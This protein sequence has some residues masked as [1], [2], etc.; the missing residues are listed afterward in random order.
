MLSNSESTSSKT[1]SIVSNGGILGR[2]K[3]LKETPEGLLQEKTF[4]HNILALI[5]ISNKLIKHKLFEMA[6]EKDNSPIDSNDFGG[7]VMAERDGFL[8]VYCA[9]GSEIMQVYREKA[10][11]KLISIAKG[12]TGHMFF[13][14]GEQAQGLGQASIKLWMVHANLRLS[15]LVELKMV[16][17]N[18]QE[19]FFIREEFAAS[20]SK[21]SFCVWTKID[22]QQ[23]TASH[24]HHAHNKA[25]DDITTTASFKNDQG[26]TSNARSVAAN[27]SGLVCNNTFCSV[28]GTDTKTINL[29][30]IAI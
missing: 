11:E 7:L 8:S 22:E 20:L 25:T 9:Q 14:A 3:K 21:L 28:Q 18:I 27:S 13:T 1:K 24:Q 6:E 26:I 23:Q 12:R 30:N 19:I 5:R 29:S 17:T 16:E 2:G 15:E 4:K 10:H